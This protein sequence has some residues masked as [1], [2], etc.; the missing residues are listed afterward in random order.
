MESYYYDPKAYIHCDDGTVEI[1]I[2]DFVGSSVYF[3]ELMHGAVA[4]WEC[5]MSQL[6]WVVQKVRCEHVVWLEHRDLMNVYVLSHKWKLT[7]LFSEISQYI[8]SEDF[9]PKRIETLQYF[10]N[11][12]DKNYKKLIKAFLRSSYPILDNEMC[13]DDIHK[14][15]QDILKYGSRLMKPRSDK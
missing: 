12:N 8:V 15:M 6:L 10:I 7:R 4:K 5:T 9:Q 2:N 3:D 11:C 14:I 13:C 1:A